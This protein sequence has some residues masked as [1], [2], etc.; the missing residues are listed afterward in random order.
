MEV[1]TASQKKFGDVFGVNSGLASGYSAKGDF[2]NA[3]KYAGKAVAQAPNENTRKQI[4]AQIA[5]L[6]EG[7]DIN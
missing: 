7:K 4:E 3:L 2:A 5:K 1:F 6:K